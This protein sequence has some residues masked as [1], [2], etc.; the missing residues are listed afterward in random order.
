MSGRRDGPRVGC[1]AAVLKEGKLLLVH[2]RRPPEADHWGLPGGKVDPMEP[3]ARAVEREIAEE[4]GI[5]IAAE[6]LLCLVEMIDAV[7][8]E[9]WIAPV[10]RVEA[11]EGEPEV[12]EPDALQGWGW[13]GLD[14]LPEPLT[15]ATVQAVAAL[16][17]AR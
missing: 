4:L 15:E 6:R 13:F 12:L 14:G 2:R 9:H 8:G 5:A 7:G 1:G 17:R 10:Y 16:R 11:F 3:V